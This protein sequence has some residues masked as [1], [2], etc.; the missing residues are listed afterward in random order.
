MAGA[1]TRSARRLLALVATA[2]CVIAALAPQAC[3]IAQPSGDVPRL[4]ESRPT[5]VHASL[6]P[7]ASAVLTH[8]PAVFIVPVE[9]VDPQAPFFYSTFVDYNP[10]TGDG[11]V[12]NT[13]AQSKYENTPGRIRVLNLAI[14]EP[15]ELDRC[16][17]IEVVV[18][19]QLKS[20]DSRNAHTPDDLPGGGPGG[21]IATW[22]YNPNG[23]LG[24]CPALDAGI[25]ASLDA[26][27]ASE[28]G[29]Q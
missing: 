13:P 28:G 18:A 29:T 6:V 17:V 15:L 25:D 4:P 2:A 1:K 9:L 24:G 5:I 20:N 23:D 21:D 10:L 8:F 7:S 26:A 11:L 19:L 27:D 3:V 16:H 22:F 12:G 14:P